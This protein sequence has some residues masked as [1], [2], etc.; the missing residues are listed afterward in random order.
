MKMLNTPTAAV[1]PKNILRIALAFGLA[2][3]A[4]ASASTVNITSPLDAATV[5]GTVGIEEANGQFSITVPPDRTEAIGMR[6]ENVS[7]GISAGG[8]NVHEPFLGLTHHQRPVRDCHR[9]RISSAVSGTTPPLD[10]RRW[11]E[12]S[13]A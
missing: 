5:S 10:S 13:S 11:A 9:S 4:A 8:G 6:A 2:F 3:A 1:M 7:Q 12:S